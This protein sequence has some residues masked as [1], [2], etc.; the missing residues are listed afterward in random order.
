M[1]DTIMAEADVQAATAAGEGKP[2]PKTN[3]KLDDIWGDENK[4]SESIQ[5]ALDQGDADPIAQSAPEPVPE[6]EPVKSAEAAPEP[7][8]EGSKIPGDVMPQETPDID[9]ATAGPQE[10]EDPTPEDVENDPKKKNAWTKIRAE[11]KELKQQV[12]EQQKRL[13]ELEQ[14][15]QSGEESKRIEELEQ[16]LLD[17]EDRIGQYDITQ[18]TAFNEKFTE[19]LVS[20]YNRV[21]TLLTK[22]NNDQGVSERIARE[23]LNPETNR[24]E[25]LGEFPITTQA[26]LGAI[27]V[28][29]DDLQERR[30]SALKN[31]R[32]TRA[33]MDE[34]Q[35][36]DT[37]STL[38]KS[39]AEDSNKAVEALR[40]EGNYL[41][42]L[43]ESD[44]DWNQSVKDRIAALQG[45][46]KDGE[47]EDMV[48]LVADGLTAR[49]YREWY[50]KEHKRAETLAKQI[51]DGIAAA[52]NLGTAT[53]A[54]EEPARPSKPR[55]MN[56]VLDK[57]WGDDDL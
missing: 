31:W 50:E 18:T 41:Y 3:E 47:R 33:A 22:T 17:Y 6:E 34:Q 38:N 21:V 26:A 51:N 55:P 7:L 54:P 40:L 23:L 56:N 32:E 25:M 42:M 24:D 46:L 19:P 20:R 37:V 16:Q 13:D 45:T 28:E 35:V 36:R 39:I 10:E 27:L 1:V 52:P 29:M 57:V 14:T 12:A 2:T 53:G 48:K 8:P 30:D 4:S 49:V 44:D 15:V 11:K 5:E 9:P 43:S